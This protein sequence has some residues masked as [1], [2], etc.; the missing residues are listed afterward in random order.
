MEKDFEKDI[1]SEKEGTEE[2]IWRS[3]LCV[4]MICCKI[5]N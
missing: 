3:L 4:E 2:I 5:V 1:G